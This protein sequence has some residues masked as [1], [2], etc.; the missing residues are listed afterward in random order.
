MCPH[1]GYQRGAVNDEQMLQFRERKARAYIYRLS[2]VSYVA[3]TI[4]LAA[5]GWYWWETGG[6]QKPASEGPLFLMVVGASI[7]LAVRVLL[8]IA[9]SRFKELRRRQG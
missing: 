6:L 1:C 5:F 7:Y 9:R 2:M 4:L 8:F 3:L